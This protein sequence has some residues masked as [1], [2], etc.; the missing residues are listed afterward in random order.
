M[1]FQFSPPLHQDAAVDAINS[2][3][4]CRSLADSKNG[5]ATFME[6]LGTNERNKQHLCNLFFEMLI[7]YGKP[8]LQP[9]ATSDKNVVIIPPEKAPVMMIP[10]CAP[11]TKDAFCQGSNP[12]IYTTI[13]TTS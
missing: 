2:V 10:T 7:A 12:K 3:S 13:Y 11:V 6:L 5:V 9:S 4:K 1:K 8:Y